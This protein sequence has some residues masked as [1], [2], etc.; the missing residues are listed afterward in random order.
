L[1]HYF[2]SKTLPLVSK[3][4]G[5]MTLVNKFCD[6]IISSVSEAQAT[7]VKAKEEYKWYY[8]RQRTPAPEINISNQVLLDASDIKTAGH[9]KASPTS[10]LAPLRSSR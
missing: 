4:F 6:W 9:P 3:P 7:L 1:E 2:N 8:D 5:D 10:V